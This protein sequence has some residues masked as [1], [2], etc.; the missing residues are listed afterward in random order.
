MD[1]S[2]AKGMMDRDMGTLAK[3][4]TENKKNTQDKIAERSFADTF[5]F[6][7]SLCAARALAANDEALESCGGISKRDFCGCGGSAR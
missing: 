2:T 4:K 5:A 3:D 1:R 6:D 7:R